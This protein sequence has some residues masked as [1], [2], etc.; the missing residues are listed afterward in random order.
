MR[1]CLNNMPLGI[2]AC[3]SRLKS[4][5]KSDVATFMTDTIHWMRF[6]V[7][8]NEKENITNDS[9]NEQIISENGSLNEESIADIC[10]DDSKSKCM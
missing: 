4:D 2:T 5:V 7:Y 10:S 1:C 3:W 6:K 9:F 8:L